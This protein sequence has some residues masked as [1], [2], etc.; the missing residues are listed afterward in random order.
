MVFNGNMGGTLVQL[1]VTPKLEIDLDDLSALAAQS[2]AY[3][4]D[5][6]TIFNKI[7]KM[8]L[9]QKK[10]EQVGRFP[11]FFNASEKIDINQFKLVAWPGYEV[12]TKLSTQGVFFNV[13]SC[14][15]FVN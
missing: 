3:M 4:A 10:Y 11:K 14:T 7:V 15:K 12:V 1:K 9:K 6:L 2:R 13:E 5:V 8:A